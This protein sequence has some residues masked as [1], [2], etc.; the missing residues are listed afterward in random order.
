MMGS[1]I[2]M[3][4]RRAPLPNVM[5]ILRCV[6]GEKTVTS[7]K[8]TTQAKAPRGGYGAFTTVTVNG[9]DHSDELGLPNRQAWLRFRYRERLVLLGRKCRSRLSVSKRAL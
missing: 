8:S 7:S 2:P 5:A 9:E 1:G 4:Q 3:S 6:S